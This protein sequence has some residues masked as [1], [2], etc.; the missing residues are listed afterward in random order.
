MRV[1]II[2]TDYGPF[3]RGL[4][5][6]GPG[7]AQASYDEQL[8]RR[9]D[10]LFGGADFYSR[11]FIA[12]GHEA[13]EV[14]A[15]NGALQSEWLKSHNLEPISNNQPSEGRLRRIFDRGVRRFLPQ[16]LQPLTTPNRPSPLRSPIEPSD[17]NLESILVAQVRTLRPD[18]VLNQAVSE[19]ESRVLHQ[20]RP[21][22]KL[23]VGQIASPFPEE[24]PYTAY[25]LMVSSLPNFVQYY[26]NR[27]IPAELNLLGFEPSVL[28]QIG[29]T[30]RDVPVSFAGSLTPD[31]RQRF[32]LLEC[33]AR[34]TDIAIWGRLAS[35]PEQ[36]P[37]LHKYRGEAWGRDMYRVLARSKI[38]INQHIDIA[39]NYANNMR[40]FE[41]T[42]MGALLIT[43]W[44]DNIAELFEPGKEV[45]CYRSPEECIA[46]IR[47]YIE[48][49]QERA[50]IAAA[51]QRRTLKD[52]TYRN[53]VTDL[54][55][56]FSAK[57]AASAR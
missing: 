36:S 28:D 10:T 5:G 15:N 53:R 23:I 18:V 6:T 40:L 57:L 17:I 8:R 24:E 52:H 55:K 13:C 12:L 56:L 14:H 38:T 46:L 41:A 49:E 20:M 11:H 35:V 19:V 2:N 3:L 51:G 16:R 42:G 54:A 39:E 31:H 43:D 9:N 50:T 34:D 26:R 7:L 37:I 30:K 48:H 4:Y 47:Y 22:T 25:D 1:I 33:L 27:G 45:V 44:K 29:T 32:D 21:Y